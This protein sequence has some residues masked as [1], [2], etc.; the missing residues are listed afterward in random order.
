MTKLLIPKPQV[1]LSHRPYLWTA[2]IRRADHASSQLWLTLAPGW[3]SFV[4]LL[5]ALEEMDLSNSVCIQMPY[6]LSR[7]LWGQAPSLIHSVLWCQYYR[8]HLCNRKIGESKIWPFL[9]GTDI[10]ETHVLARSF[11][12]GLMAIKYMAV[13]ITIPFRLGVQSHI[14]AKKKDHFKLFHKS[15]DNFA[16]CSDSKFS[17]IVNT[18]S[19]GYSMGSL[20]TERLFSGMMQPDH[21]GSS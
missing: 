20:T 1:T 10:V 5:S 8:F 15:K 16:A 7:K 21:L 4:D 6:S 3:A 9:Y 12:C 11:P 2:Q 17:E 13:P 14:T 19:K 18:L